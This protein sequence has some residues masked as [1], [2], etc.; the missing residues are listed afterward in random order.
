MTQTVYKAI[1]DFTGRHPVFAR[2]TKIKKG[3]LIYTKQK[4]LA[5]LEYYLVIGD[6]AGEITLLK[7]EIDWLMLHKYIRFHKNI[8][9]E[10]SSN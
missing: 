1:K 8:R 2:I 3:D 7:D 5:G 4:Y 9:H 10:D 6:M